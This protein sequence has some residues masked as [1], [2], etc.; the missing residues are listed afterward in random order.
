MSTPSAPPGQ[1]IWSRECSAALHS[2]NR[3]AFR[4]LLSL[5]DT[6]AIWAA[7]GEYHRKARLSHG[8]YARFCL[9]R[10]GRRAPQWFTA[11]PL[12]KSGHPHHPLYLKA[13][14]ALLPLDIDAYLAART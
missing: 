8:L 12:L 6:P 14:T 1:T 4:Y 9:R 5:S 10:K 3:K 11:G 2:E 7:L 13:T